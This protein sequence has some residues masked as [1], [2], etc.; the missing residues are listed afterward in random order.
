MT[1]LLSVTT[2]L[3][4]LSTFLFQLPIP[5]TGGYFNFGDIMIFITAIAFG[6]QVGGFAGGI[7]SA[8]SDL[9]GGFGVFAPF[10]LIIKGAE[11]LT[12]G[13][14]SRR[15]FRGRDIAA[16]ATGSI[17]MVG[18]YFA[19]EAFVIALFFGASDSTGIAA[20]LGEVPFNVLQVVAGGLVG[21]PVGWALRYAF[22]ETILAFSPPYASGKKPS[23]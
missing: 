5:A 6:P 9:L 3:V 22:R 15:T 2:A 13:L 7:G 11:G 20:A 21:I 17:A 16:W 8:L 14:I 10:T 12:V 23:Y 1:A 19:A 4:F 18:G